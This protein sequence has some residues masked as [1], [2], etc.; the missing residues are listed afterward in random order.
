MIEAMACG[1]PVISTRRGAVTEIVEHGKTG[2]VVDNY[3]DMEEPSVLELADS[4]DP[5][6]IRKHV[7][8]NFSPEIMVANYVAAYEATID[9]AG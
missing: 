1:T 3:R 4:L 7:E 6:V 5:V 2:V 9:A 8:A